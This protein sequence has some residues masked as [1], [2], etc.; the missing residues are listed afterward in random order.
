MTEIIERLKDY[1]NERIK[2]EE[3]PIIQS[4]IG[5]LIKIYNIKKGD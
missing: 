1:S 5:G 4:M 2:V 3:I